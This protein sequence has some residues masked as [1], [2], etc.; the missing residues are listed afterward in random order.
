MHGPLGVRSCPPCPGTCQGPL[1]GR[2]LANGAGQG[3]HVWND[4]TSGGPKGC[5]ALRQWQLPSSSQ[6]QVVH[7]ICQHSTAPPIASPALRPVIDAAGPSSKHPD[8]SWSLSAQPAHELRLCLISPGLAIQHR[9]IQSLT[10]ERPSWPQISG[11]RWPPSFA[12]HKERWLSRRQTLSGAR[13]VSNVARVLLRAPP[14][15][16]ICPNA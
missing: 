6:G 5:P 15:Y 9:H 11:P 3:R 1:A 16:L 14:C 2:P 8:V 4:W 7:P 10:A 12:R 13:T